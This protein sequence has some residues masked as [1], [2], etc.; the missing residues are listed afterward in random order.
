MGTD[1]I[2]GGGGNDTIDYSGF[3]GAGLNITMD[4]KSNPGNWF[5]RDWDVPATFV[6]FDGGRSL[7]AMIENVVGSDFNDNI[8]GNSGDNLLNGGLGV[9]TLSG[10]N[11]NDT[12]IAGGDDDVLTGGNGTDTFIFSTDSGN[13]QVT[14]LSSGDALIIEGIV[15]Q[16]DVSY[17]DLLD[18]SGSVINVGDS[19][20][21]LGRCRC[22]G[23]VD[24]CGLQR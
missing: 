18:G 23:P 5:F 2:I 8:R 14:D 21:T 1:W 20:I 13:D 12:L 19:V 17:S 22:D 16:S 15:S 24:R 11:G 4:N 10:G 3:E 7:F 6:F 9:D